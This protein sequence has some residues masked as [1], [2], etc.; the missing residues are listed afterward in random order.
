MTDD[1]QKD[2]FKTTDGG[3]T[4]TKSLAVTHDGYHVD[5]AAIV[6][7]PRDPDVLRVGSV[8]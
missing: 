2:V 7:D 8:E 3:G 5:A 1:P 6:M 4:W